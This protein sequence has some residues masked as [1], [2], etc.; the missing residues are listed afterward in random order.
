MTKDRILFISILSVVLFMRGVCIAYAAECHGLE[1]YSGSPVTSYAVRYVVYPR[2]E[3]NEIRSQLDPVVKKV[4]SEFGLRESMLV[5]GSRPRPGEQ[6]PLFLGFEVFIERLK[7][8]ETTATISV[9]G[10][11]NNFLSARA[12]PRVAHGSKSTVSAQLQ[13][14][15]TT[16]TRDAI[17]NPFEFPFRR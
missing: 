11:L 4:A 17:C 14:T 8:D 5:L 15:V 12:F 16:L 6:Y 13:T 10:G 1:K 7:D 2:S 3:L 9:V